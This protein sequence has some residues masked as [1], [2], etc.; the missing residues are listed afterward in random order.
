MPRTSRHGPPISRRYATPPCSP[1]LAGPRRSSPVFDRPVVDP[2]T[3]SAIPWCDP[4]PR[5]VLDGH[6][7]TAERPRLTDWLGHAQRAAIDSTARAID[8][9]S[10][11]DR[12]RIGRGSTANRAVIDGGSNGRRTQSHRGSA[13]DRRSC[14]A[15]AQRHRARRPAG[16]R[17][18]HSAAPVRRDPVR[19]TCAAADS[20]RLTL[21]AVQTSA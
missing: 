15:G 5:A 2:A 18:V 10:A 11:A 6:A 7:R 12:A 3:R 1:V 16:A 17:P 13:V 14:G 20:Q 21:C 9:E 8:R 19:P 4:R